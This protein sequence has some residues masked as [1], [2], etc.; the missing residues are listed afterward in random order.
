VFIFF[1]NFSSFAQ[2][3]FIKIWVA[4]SVAGKIKNYR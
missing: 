3:C 1:K 2:I 4:S